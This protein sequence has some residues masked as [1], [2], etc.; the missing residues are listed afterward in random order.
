MAEVSSS[1]AWPVLSAED[2]SGGAAELRQ[3][4]ESCRMQCIP[5]A[6]VLQA[7]PV[8]VAGQDMGHVQ[9]LVE[10]EGDLPPILVHRETMRVVDGMHRLRAAAAQGRETIKAVFFAGSEQDAFVI[11]V[12]L[13]AMHGLRLTPVDRSAAVARIVVSHP[14]WSDRAIASAAGVAARTVAAIRKRVGGNVAPL[15]SRIGRDGRVRPLSSA[16]GRSRAGELMA[17]CPDA[18]LREVAQASGVSVSTANDVRA[19]LRAGR[20][21]VPEQQR[22]GRSAQASTSPAIQQRVGVDAEAGDGQVSDLEQ[23]RRDP[24]MRFNEIGR[25][26]LRLLDV[27]ALDS[28]EWQRYVDGVPRH[29]VR[30][31]VNTARRCAAAWEN[32]AERLEKRQGS[33]RMSSSSEGA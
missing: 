10:V 25:S 23:L 30:S 12:K 4:L 2:I 11:A 27:G 15:D 17:K 6:S 9:A 1:R 29:C 33:M 19:R 5:I 8:R 22:T 3:K 31:V 21:L 13:N 24:S 20:D 32:F 7:P 18:S 28:D 16:E 14:Q 26:V